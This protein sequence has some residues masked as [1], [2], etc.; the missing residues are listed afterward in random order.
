MSGLAGFGTLGVA[1]VLTVLLF[2][3][4]G[5]NAGQGRRPKL[6]WMPVAILSFIDG[7]ALAIAGDPLKFNGLVTKCA[8]MISKGGNGTVTVTAFAGLLLVI[9][10]W[11]KM[12][13]R[14][15]FI[16]VVFLWF[17]F[18]AAGGTPAALSG[19]ARNIANTF[20]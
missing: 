11:A 2:L 1:L 14:T 12:Q 5:K 19:F 20:V 6:E 13:T 7:A 10:L 3:G 8:D 17:S 15:T 18:N 16:L 9:V 4:T